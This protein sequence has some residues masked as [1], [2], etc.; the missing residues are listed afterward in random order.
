ME[1]KEN[2]SAKKEEKRALVSST[3]SIKEFEEHVSL[4][5]SAK[6]SGGKLDKSIRISGSGRING[7]LECNGLTASGSLKGSGNLTIHGDVSSSGSFIIA[8]FLYGDEGADFSGSTQIGNLVKLQGTLEASGSFKSGHFVTV[9]QEITLAGSSNING[10]L[11]SEKNITINGST[12][13][14]GN[15]VGESVLFGISDAIRI[16]KQHYRVH[17][18]IHAKDNVDLTRTHVAGDVKGKTVNIGRGSEIFGDVY[19]VDNIEID[20]K[21]KLAKEPI[22]IKIEEL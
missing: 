19:Y 1:K 5:G 4:S 8:G 9:D 14:E 2:D 22:Q 18:S 7:D 16:K 20:K 3:G 10:N 21:A 6:I 12:N 11:S 15:V 17:G 13:I